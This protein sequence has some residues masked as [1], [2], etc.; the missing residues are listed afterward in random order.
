MMSKSIKFKDN[1]FL[2]STGIVHNKELLSSILNRKRLE[3]RTTTS[4]NFNDNDFITPGLYPLGTTYSNA[5]TSGTIYGVIMVLTND[6]GIWRKTDTSS[7]LWQLIFTTGGE[8]YQ[9]IGIN[10]S[11]PGSWQKLH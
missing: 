4:R 1:L 11:T 8:I 5:F 10:S 3:W 2:D 6:G 9:R 7:W